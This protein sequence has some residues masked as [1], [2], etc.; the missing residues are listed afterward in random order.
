[1]TVD[2]E[3]KRAPAYRVACIQWKGPWNE[4]KI[5]RH[6]GEL[7]QWAKQ[8]KVRTGKWIFREPDERRWEVCIE[9]RG[10]TRPGRGI[11]M[12][13]LRAS[14]V[15]RV[16]FDPDEVSPRVIYHGLNDW[17]KWRKKEGE[18]KSVGSSRELYDGDPWKD[19]K[20]WAHTEVQYLVRR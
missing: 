19:S 2:F 4:S 20:A 11:R 13:T 12:R 9:V 7:A 18:V 1:M 5:R 3:F 14:A 17:L 8:Q 15:A 16:V 6:F 10:R